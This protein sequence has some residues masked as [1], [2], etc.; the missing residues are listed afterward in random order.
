[1][2]NVWFIT[3]EDGD[4]LIVSFA[5][6][7][8]VSGNVKSLTLLRTPKYEFALDESERGV[9][10]SFED[11]PDDR[12]ELLKKLKIKD[13]TVSITT[14][15][16]IHMVNIENVDPMEIH[17]SERI[18]KKMN[19]DGRFELKISVSGNGN[20]RVRKNSKENELRRTI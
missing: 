19:F 3:N 9:K 11:F 16:G 13:N 1:M 7:I 6:P 18:L 14:D 20:S 2:E 15:Y 4:D 10:V 12:N 5:I 8:D 17:E